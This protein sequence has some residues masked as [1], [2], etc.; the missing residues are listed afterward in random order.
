MA[1]DRKNVCMRQVWMAALKPTPQPHPLTLS[2]SR[3]QA[4]CKSWAREK[5]GVMVLTNTDITHDFN[6]TICFQRTSWHPTMNTDRVTIKHHKSHVGQ[7]TNRAS[8]TDGRFPL[9]M[10][11]EGSSFSVWGS[12]L[13]QDCL[14]GCLLSFM[15]YKNTCGIVFRKTPTTT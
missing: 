15:V 1:N 9:K 8:E 7:K 10:L 12:F 14:C 6:S 3:Q 4:G 13:K 5:H 2:T 11:A